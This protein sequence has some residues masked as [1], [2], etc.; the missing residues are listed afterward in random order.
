MCA[1]LELVC[2]L[3]LHLDLVKRTEFA[4]DVA[5]GMTALHSARPNAIVHRDLKPANLLVTARF[6]V[7]SHCSKSGS[8]ALRWS[9]PLIQLLCLLFWFMLVVL[10]HTPLPWTMDDASLLPVH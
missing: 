9:S 7:R 2:P 6:E 8:D 5:R 3:G 10:P 1:C 4:M